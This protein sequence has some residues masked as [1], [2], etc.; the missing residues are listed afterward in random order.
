MSTTRQNIS[1]GSTWEPVLGYSRAVRI[2]DTVAVAGTTGAGETAEEQARAALGAIAAALTEAGAGLEN[3]IRTRIF[4]TDI[5]DFDAV[6]RVHGEVFGE[7]RPALTAVAVS[8]LAAPGL[9]VEIEADA[10]L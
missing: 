9:F 10:V 4:L 1:S 2:G 6:G 5:A 3:V 8:A 7:I